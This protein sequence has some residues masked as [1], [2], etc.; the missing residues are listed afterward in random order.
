ML[1]GIFLKAAREAKDRSLDD[2]S[3][4]CLIDGIP[5]AKIQEFS[6]REGEA[7]TGA[8]YAAFYHGIN[9]FHAFNF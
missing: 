6:G 3:R 2:Q 8:V 1:A 7:H 9:G 5:P 4:Q